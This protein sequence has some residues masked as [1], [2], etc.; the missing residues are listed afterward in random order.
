MLL[1]G[2]RSGCL[3]LEEPRVPVRLARLAGLA[4]GRRAT[5]RRGHHGGLWRRR[6]LGF[7]WGL[8]AAGL[9]TTGGEHGRREMHSSRSSLRSSYWLLSRE[10]AGAEGECCIVRSCYLQGRTQERLALEGFFPGATKT[11]VDV[12]AA[13]LGV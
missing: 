2:L 8:L 6:G 12:E 5:G 4:L 10:R 3:G 9:G 7:C 13:V 1:N 11:S